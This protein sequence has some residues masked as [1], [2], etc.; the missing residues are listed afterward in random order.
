M[1]EFKETA[2]KIVLYFS[3]KQDTIQCQEIAAT[4]Q[5]KIAEA[6]KPVAFNLHEVEYVSS[7]FLRLCLQTS[8]TV[9]MD[10]FEVTDLTPTVKKV[11]KIAGFDQL[12]RGA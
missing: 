11:F 9:G 7:A 8:K 4:V 12:L 10:R 2:E 1:V 5:R 6:A 3:G